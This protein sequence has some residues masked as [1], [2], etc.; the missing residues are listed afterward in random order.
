MLPQAAYGRSG[1][2]IPH[3]AQNDD[4]AGAPFGA[5]AG[6]AQIKTT[7]IAWVSIALFILQQ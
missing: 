4:F 7:S 2:F 1:G 3:L 6:R 5:A